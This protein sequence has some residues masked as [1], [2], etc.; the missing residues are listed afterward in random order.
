MLTIRYNLQ[1]VV[2]LQNITGIYDT[3]FNSDCSSGT[4]CSIL[5]SSNTY[6]ANKKQEQ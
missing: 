1:R 2:P 4:S 3:I 5:F 6:S